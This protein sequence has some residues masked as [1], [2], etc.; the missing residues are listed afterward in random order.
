M[1]DGNNVLE[2]YGKVS[3]AVKRAQ[4]G[5]GPTLIECKTYRWE[6]HHLGDPC[7]YRT[8][9]E[10]ER[11]RGNCPIKRL[12]SIL[13]QEKILAKEYWEK[14]DNETKTKIGEAEAFAKESPDPNPKQL[15]DYIW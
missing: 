12:K 15:L 11:W 8:R 10:V 1:V 6:G 9:E 14:I 2:V 3:E 5:D 4:A 13:E 7:V